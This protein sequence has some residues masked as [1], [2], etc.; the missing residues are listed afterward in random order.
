LLENSNI[1]VF[2][3]RRIRRH[4]PV[5]RNLYLRTWAHDQPRIVPWVKGAVLAIR[6]TAFDAVAGFDESYFMYFEDADLCYRLKAAGWE[7]HF[8]PET[9]VVHVGGASTRQFR[10]EM[11]LRLLASTLRFYQCH[12][13]GLRL[14][15]V[16]LIV[17]A[18]ILARWVTGISR[19]C[20]TR[21]STKRAEIIAD[22]VAYRCV[23]FGH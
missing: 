5:L 6:R 16:A 13:S 2:L 14:A 20:L 9:T 22:T 11:T 18:L 12:A 1:A 19:L 10:T 23:L 17:K 8:T 3:G 21:D 7:V 4:F 15:E